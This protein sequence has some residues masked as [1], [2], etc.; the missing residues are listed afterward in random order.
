MI[1]IEGPTWRDRYL[2]LGWNNALTALLAVPIAAWVVAVLSISALSDR[3]AFIGMVLLCA[4][5]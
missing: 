4:V 3:A 1:D 2:T 5:Y